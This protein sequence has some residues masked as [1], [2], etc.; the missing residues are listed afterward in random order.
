MIFVD[1]CKSIL[2]IFWVIFIYVQPK[3][4]KK[5]MADF[6]W[7]QQNLKKKEKKNLPKCKI[8]VN[9]VR[10]TGFFF[11]FFIALSKENIAQSED[12]SL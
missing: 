6:T 10:K 1:F 5:K 9:G 4:V 8:W 7:F 3:S 12:H 11:F 2:K